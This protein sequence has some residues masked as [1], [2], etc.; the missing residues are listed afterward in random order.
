MVAGICQFLVVLL[1]VVGQTDT[2]LG[3]TVRIYK[4][5]EL[6]VGDIVLLEHHLCTVVCKVVQYGKHEMLHVHLRLVLP[7]RFEYGQAQYVVGTFVE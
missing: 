7:S 4:S 2:A 6:V 1:V 3:G 5:E